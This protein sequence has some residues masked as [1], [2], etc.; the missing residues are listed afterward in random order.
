M[1]IALVVVPWMVKRVGQIFNP[2]QVVVIAHIHDFSDWY[3]SALTA[4]PL[5][6]VI[7]L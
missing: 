2:L 1:S 3:D 6:A 7:G 4:L 5:H